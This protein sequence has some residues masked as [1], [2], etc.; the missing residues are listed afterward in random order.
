[1][2]RFRMSRVAVAAL[3]L[4]SVAAACGDDDDPAEPRPDAGITAMQLMVG[5][6]LV[7]VDS[8]GSV[9]GELESIPFGAT[10]VTAGF[11]GANGQPASNVTPGRYVF[12]VVFADTLALDWQPGT[13]FNGTLTASAGGTYVFT[14]RLRDTD[15]DG[16]EIFLTRTLPIDVGVENVRMVFGADTLLVAAGTT[17][18]GT[19]GGVPVGPVPARFEFLDAA[20]APA[21]IITGEDFVV[22][23]ASSD[24]NIVA[25]T[26]DGPFAGTLNGIAPGV[27]SIAV[28]LRSTVNSA[29]VFAHV[30][31][32]IVE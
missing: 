17:L 2:G 15:N 13:G 20:G 10:E 12:D 14:F 27:A 23:V 28:R 32:V 30:I 7:T 22:S 26:Q 25:W 29:L 31:T 16:T 9:T 18:P 1:M 3:L 11:L 4:A 19:L 8:S 5:D 6:R 21:P 24:A